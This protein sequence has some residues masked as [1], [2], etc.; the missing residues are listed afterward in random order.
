MNMKTLKLASLFLSN[1]KDNK[2]TAV[3]PKK[4]D[5]NF[6][7]VIRGL[8]NS[9]Q[10]KVLPI[11]SET[12][13]ITIS[14]KNGS[15]PYIESLKKALLTK[16][17]SL[18]GLSLDR[19]NVSLLKTFLHQC[20]FTIERAEGLL[21]ELAKDNPKGDINLA[22]FFR[23][24][25]KADLLGEKTHKGIV[26]ESSIIP[27]IESGL[28]DCGLSQRQIDNALDLAK[29]EG[30]K[31]DLGKF[32]T[33]LKKETNKGLEPL[34]RPMLNQFIASLE[35]A[36]NQSV[37]SKAVS[38][39]VLDNENVSRQI[40]TV[41]SKMDSRI[42]Y[43]NAGK[44]AGELDTTNPLP[45]EVK[46]IVVESSIIPHIESRLRDCGLSQRQIDNA[47]DLAKVE[48]GKID[49]GKFITG[50]KKETNKGLEPLNRPM[51][52]QFIASLE[53]AANQSVSS[54]AVSSKV[55]DNEN[56]SRQIVTVLSKMD[57][58]IDYGNAGK[59]A[60]E[61]DT[62]NPLPPEVKGI[63]EHIADMAKT[64]GETNRPLVF[65]LGNHDMKAFLSSKGKIANTKNNNK[66]HYL[67]V[68][69]SENKDAMSMKY[70]G[71]TVKQ[72]DT[73][74]EVKL[75]LDLDGETGLRKGVKET[76]RAEKSGIKTVGMPH[77]AGASNPTE[78][79]NI[80]DKGQNPVR[81]SF[82]SYLINQVGRQIARSIHNGKNVI[83]LQLKPPELGT[84]KIEV[85]IEDN[86]LRLSMI[87]Q[88]K[89]VK[90]IL[91]S[92][93]H[94]LKEA[95]VEQGIKPDKIDIQLDYNPDQSLTNSNKH[96][97]KHREGGKLPRHIT[98][99]SSLKGE[100][101]GREV[102]PKTYN[103]L[104]GNNLLNLMA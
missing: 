96:S 77:N 18:Q 23:K 85:G 37:S 52:N 21:R 67:K 50:L 5:G 32:I 103:V 47:L 28:R 4:G 55:L 104:P 46:G 62:T 95:L 90:H 72:P 63:I 14:A 98:G 91:L 71:E 78:S 24:V 45:P 56:V 76:G 97:N 48:G 54:K 99:P 40:V 20:G 59:A 12:P 26:V 100:V 88:D 27:H 33:G 31:I 69:A 65:P 43:G 84:I 22:A 89:I 30:G 39:K 35:K 36:A 68:S 75:P 42:D 16:G 11:N 83:K 49:L 87:T 92:N 38:S 66:E 60:G 29:V 61:L 13:Q 101:R 51:L 10:K 74:R 70:N 2:Y 86:R 41:L 79:I 34:N 19:E 7:S 64:V 53:K 44:A 93:I 73:K 58:R 102:S 9:L 81:N 82:P 80:A 57:S 6:S 1:G 17:T 3:A 15:N 94:E 25:S 8:L